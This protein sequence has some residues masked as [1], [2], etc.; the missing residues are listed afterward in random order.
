MTP[1]EKLD[2]IHRLILAYNSSEANIPQLSDD[3]VERLHHACV[4]GKLTPEI[5]QEVDEVIEAATK[6]IRKHYERVP[7]PSATPNSS[8]Y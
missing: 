5:R 4:F 1:T 2:K 8:T 6:A 7:C 3:L